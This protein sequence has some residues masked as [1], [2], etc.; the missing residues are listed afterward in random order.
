MGLPFTLP[1]PNNLYK[2]IYNFGLIIILLP[3]FV[4]SVVVL[5]PTCV[6]WLYF[7]LPCTCTLVP[8]ITLNLNIVN[9]PRIRLI[10]QILDINV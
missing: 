3:I 7:R 10:N 2:F 8:V 6:S 9:S 1:F 4:Y 5:L